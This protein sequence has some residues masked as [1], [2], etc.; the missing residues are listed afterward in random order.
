MPAGQDFLA[1]RA[2]GLEGV[3]GI[4]VGDL[5][6]LVGVGERGKMGELAAPA[7]THRVGQLVVK[8]SE[9]QERFA[10]AV[11]VAHEQQRDHRRQQQQPRGGAQR[12][13]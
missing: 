11:V 8:I 2:G 12:L 7:F 1:L 5:L 4:R 3:G 13:R 6:A 9:E 10:A